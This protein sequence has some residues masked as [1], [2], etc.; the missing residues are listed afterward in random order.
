MAPAHWWDGIEGELVTSC[1]LWDAAH[2]RVVVTAGGWEWFDEGLGANLE[3]V[4]RI[5]P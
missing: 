5:E 2:V 4:R 3:T 1:R